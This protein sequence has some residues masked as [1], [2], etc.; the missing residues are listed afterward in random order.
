MTVPACSYGTCDERQIPLLWECRY[1][2]GKFVVSNNS[3]MQKKE[4]R[5]IVCAAYSLLS[6]ICVYPVMNFSVFFIDDFPAP[7]PEGHHTVILK[8]YGRA[9]ENFYKNIW[10]PDM[11]RLGKEYGLKY[12]GLLVETYNDNVKGPFSAEQDLEAPV[13]WGHALRR[14]RSRPHDTTICFM[15]ETFDIKEFLIMPDA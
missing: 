12:T 1:G 8:Q 11:L 14:G 5:G 3:I 9:I 10:W 2:K 13:F 4:A 7:M 15:S 6:D